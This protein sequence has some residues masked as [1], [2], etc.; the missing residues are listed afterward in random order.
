MQYKNL[1][2]TG[3]KVS[4]LCFGTMTFGWQ[5]DQKTSKIAMDSALR[6]EISA[7]SPEPPPATDRWE[8]RS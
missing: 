6:A 1:G 5:A 3:V 2:N 4:S 8:E 7:L